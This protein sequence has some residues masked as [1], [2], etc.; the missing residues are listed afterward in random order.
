[1]YREHG[2]V[3]PARRH[4]LSG[5]RLWFD[6]YFGERFA[7]ENGFAWATATPRFRLGDG[8]VTEAPLTQRRLTG[9]AR[10]NVISGAGGSRQ[11]FVKGGYGWSQHDVPAVVLG[12]DTLPG[13]GVRRGRLPTLLPSTKWWPNTT[14]RWVGT[15]SFPSRKR[16]AGVARASSS[17]NTRRARK[18]E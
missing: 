16:C 14:Q 5:H 9:G 15:K 1:M 13:T 11:L 18:P 7:L 4:V 8:T 3:P 17:T 12:T 6:L 2:R 10:Y